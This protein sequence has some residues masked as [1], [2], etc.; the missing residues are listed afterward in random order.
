MVK[1]E[2]ARLGT[3]GGKLTGAGTMDL[4]L[5]V[6]NGP[7]L[8]NLGV[9]SPEAET[10]NLRDIPMADNGEGRD[11]AEQ[12]PASEQSLFVSDDSAEDGS[13]RIQ[14][15]QDTEGKHEPAPNDPED[16]VEDKKKMAL[17]TTYDGFSIYGR[18]LCLVVKRRGVTKGKDRGGGTGQA[19]MEEWIASTQLAEGQL[20]EG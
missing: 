2:K 6:D 12:T 18:I 11:S 14:R 17:N 7:D 1:S 19:M 13:S 5:E 10:M 15:H 8:D 9:E 16:G 20:M 4:P 3:V